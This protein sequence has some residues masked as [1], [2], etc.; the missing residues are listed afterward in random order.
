VWESGG[1]EEEPFSIS[2]HSK[3][4]SISENSFEGFSIY[5]N[6][7]TT[8][9]YF[10]A[11]DKIK[12]ISVYNLIGQELLRTTPNAIQS[13][14]SMTNFQTGVYIVKV[15]VGKQFGTYKILKE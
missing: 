2:A 4:F 14:L 6:P 9:L 12:T 10:N 8:V 13:E 7:V 11:L 15:K 3:T 1:D 5:P